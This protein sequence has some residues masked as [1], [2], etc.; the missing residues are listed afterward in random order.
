MA[1]R[2]TKRHILTWATQPMDVYVAALKDPVWRVRRQAAAALELLGDRQA[3]PPLVARLTDDDVRVRETV[4]RA[5]GRLGGKRAI[6]P[7][8]RV[9]G[10]SDHAVQAQALDALARLN[11]LAQVH[12]PAAVDAL[13]ATLQGPSPLRPGAAAALGNIGAPRA[14]GP[15]VDALRRAAAEYPGLNMG[16]AYV[17]AL[18][19]VGLPALPALLDLILDEDS[20]LRAYAALGLVYVSDDKRAID[21]LQSARHDRNL[22]VRRNAVWS[23]RQAADP[24]LQGRLTDR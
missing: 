24:T 16:T 21:A 15:L 8:V 23:L 13:I 9:L 10:D 18:G 2:S 4:V 22:D 11:A 1:A 19:S 7:L 6:K 20:A 14:I 3:V 12:D 17:V 5:L